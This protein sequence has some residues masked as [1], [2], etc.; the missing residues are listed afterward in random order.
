VKAPLVGYEVGGFP[1]PL[2]GEVSRKA[3]NIF[4]LDVTPRV[5]VGEWLAFEGLFGQQH[6]DAPTFTGAEPSP[7]SACTV[8]PNAVLPVA[9]TVQRLGLGVRYSTVDAF[10]RRRA[11]YPV[12]VSYRHLET[13]TGDANAPKLFR[14]QIQLRIYYRIWR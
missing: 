12:E 14:D 1:Y 5:F 10:L 8:L 2:V 13:I 7:C 6:S 11:K 3:G 9:Q 4:G